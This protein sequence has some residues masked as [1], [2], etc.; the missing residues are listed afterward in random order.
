MGYSVFQRFKSFFL[1]TGILCEISLVGA[2]LCTVIFKIGAIHY[3]AWGSIIVFL[4]DV[5]IILYLIRKNDNLQIQKVL[6]GG[7]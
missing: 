5:V 1:L 2:L 4:L 3:I 6:K 7:I